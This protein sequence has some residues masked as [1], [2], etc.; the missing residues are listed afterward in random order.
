MHK[1]T[2][3]DALL[4]HSRGRHGKVEVIPT[5]PYGT[6]FDLSLAYTSG[7]AA[8]SCSRLYVS[9]GVRKENI[10]MVD[11]KGVLNRKRTG[12]NKYKQEFII[13]YCENY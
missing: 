11:S 3:E 8:I 10:I 1:V 7:V 4:Y 13:K 5:K 12:L 6:Q 9:M 2:Q